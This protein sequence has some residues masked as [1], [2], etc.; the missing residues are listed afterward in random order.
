MCQKSHQ[1]RCTTATTGKNDAGVTPVVRQLQ[2]PPNGCQ[3]TQHRSCGALYPQP[4]PVPIYTAWWTEARVWTTCLELHLAAEQPGI[5]PA[6]SRSLIRHP[7]RYTTKPHF[8]II[9][10]V[11]CI[12]C[13]CRHARGREE[14]ESAALQNGNTKCNGLL[15]LWGPQVAESAYASCLAR[16]VMSSVLRFLSYYYYYY[17]YYLFTQT[18]SSFYRTMHFSANARS[19]DRMSSV[20]PSVCLSVCNVGGLWSHRLEILETN[21]TDN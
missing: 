5:E 16:W 2:G 9:M 8:M 19:W 12:S 14:W 3:H 21:C 18:H 6:T 17:Y 13:V 10:S 7:N 1:G 15:P 11:C 4:K 20:C